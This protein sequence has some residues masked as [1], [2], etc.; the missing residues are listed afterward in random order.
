MSRTFTLILSTENDEERFTIEDKETGLDIRLSSECKLAADTSAV[1]DLETSH[2]DACHDEMSV[3]EI[4]G[5]TTEEADTLTRWRTRKQDGISSKQLG[6]ILDKVVQAI[7]KRPIECG[8]QH[9]R[10]VLKVE[11]TP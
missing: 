8:S 1:Y 5:L 3:A 10:I 9:E 4:I 11:P 2:C 6:E 7:G